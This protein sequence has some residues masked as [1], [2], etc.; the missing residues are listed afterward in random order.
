MNLFRYQ[1]YI[2]TI[3]LNGT[4]SA[5]FSLF[6]SFQYSW[7]YIGNIKFADDWIRTAVLWCQKQLLYQLNHNHC[8]NLDKYTSHHLPIHHNLQLCQL[9]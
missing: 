1:V 2:L 9:N 5:T 6:S 7:Q 3:F 8:Q 4:F